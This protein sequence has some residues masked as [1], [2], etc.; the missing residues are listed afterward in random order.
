M[1]QRP[2]RQQR[3]AASR[4]AHRRASLWRWVAVAAAATVLAVLIVVL[5]GRGRAPATM[6]EGTQVVPV[7]SAR[8]RP[9]PIAYPHTPP[10][11]GDHAAAWQNC[12]FYSRPVPSEQAVHSLEHGAVWIAYRPDLADT[13]VAILR[14]LARQSFVLVSPFPGLPSPVVA[15]AWGHQ[16]RLPSAE[17]PRLEQ[18]VRFFRQG[19]QTPEPGA[20][21]TG[22]VGD[23]E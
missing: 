6:P 14:R 21:C 4:R 18:F 23:P 2:T 19:P 22:G 1:S 12:G 15:S 16:L 5:V 11:G 13:Q 17:D 3:R 9:G 8:H 7:A 20:R 10:V